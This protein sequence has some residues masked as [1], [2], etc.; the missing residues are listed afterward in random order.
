MEYQPNVYDY[1]SNSKSRASSLEEVVQDAQIDKAVFVESTVKKIA[2][3][4]LGL[5]IRKRDL[6]EEVER[7]VSIRTA[8]L[9]DANFRL[10]MQVRQLKQKLTATAIE[11]RYT[12]SERVSD[13]KPQAYGGNIINTVISW[14][15]S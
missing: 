6:D 2:L 4:N 15:K 10:H 3:T 12:K 9:K 5:A 1:L 8:T 7:R 14:F 13:D 11:E